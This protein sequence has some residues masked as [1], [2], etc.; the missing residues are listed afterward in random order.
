[1]TI[2]EILMAALIIGGFLLGL[3]LM[4]SPDTAKWGNRLTASSMA[5][6][7]LITIY[8][9][10]AFGDY[11]LWIFIFIGSGIGILLGQNVKMVQMPQMV[12]LLNGFGG[13]ASAL[14]AGTEASLAG[15]NPGGNWFFWLVASLALAIG[16]LTFSGSVIAALKLQNWVTQRPVSIKGHDLV[17][18]G[19]LLIGGVTII[20]TI[21]MG[22]RYFLFL[23]LALIILFTCYGVLLVFR[24]GG[25][26]MP[27]VISLLNSFSG[28]AASVSG[29]V[30]G[31]AL[32]AGAG[33][34]VGVAGM[35][36]TRIMCKAMNRSLIDVIGGI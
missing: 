24:I 6:A 12:A 19:L 28:L 23:I 10:G 34:L 9:L 16:T 8:T 1:M 33:A 30:V 35:I 29:L 14:V 13:G 11:S 17:Q 25:A 26:D 3:R 18:K 4:Q 2:Y 36:L 21:L 15:L 7:L 20:L 27:V 22:S 32:L 31:N 5:L